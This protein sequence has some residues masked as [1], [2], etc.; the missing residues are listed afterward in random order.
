MTIE[1]H[2]IFQETMVNELKNRNREVKEKRRVL[3]QDDMYHG[4]LEDILL[5]KM[6][7]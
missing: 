3:K 1:D 7:C 4:A 2:I 5:G 6:S